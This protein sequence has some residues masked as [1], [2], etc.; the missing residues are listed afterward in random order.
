[1][2]ITWY[3]DTCLWELLSWRESTTIVIIP[4]E[5]FTSLCTETQTV[6]S[7]QQEIHS[8]SHTLYV[9]MKL[10]PEENWPSWTDCWTSHLQGE[11]E[12]V[13]ERERGTD[14]I[15]T[16]W[17]QTYARLNKK[18]SLVSALDATSDLWKTVLASFRPHVSP[19][20]GQDF[21]KMTSHMT[22]LRCLCMW[23]R[24]WVECEWVDLLVELLL[25]VPH[26]LEWPTLL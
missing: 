14:M 24:G 1:M 20:R 26:C 8:I 12:S 19:R 7:V 6:L 25:L 4:Q 5:V 18:I 15:I 3:S 22:G 10:P 2:V 9:F 21:V 11:G 23:E 13:C 16:L 17:S